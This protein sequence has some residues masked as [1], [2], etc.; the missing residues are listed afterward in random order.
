M[1]FNVLVT[2]RVRMKG[3][4]SM[5]E[6]PQVADRFGVVTLSDMLSTDWEDDTHFVCYKVIGPDGSELPSSEQFRLRKSIRGQLEEAG[7]KITCWGFVGDWDLNENV[8]DE[9]LHAAGWDGNSK[10]KPKITWT[11]DL[12]DRFIEET[13]D[14]VE[15]LRA[16][17]LG[18]AYIYL[19]NHG[20][21]MIHLY[22]EDQPATVHE[23][24]IRGMLEEYRKLGYILD[25]ACVDWT[26]LFRAPRVMRN[27]QFTGHQQ[28]FMKWTHDNWTVA[29]LAPRMTRKVDDYAD[30]S[31][32]VGDRPDPE[33]ALALLV[34]DLSTGRKT[35]TYKKLKALLHRRDCQKLH[36][37]LTGSD[38]TLA[39]GQ[40]DVELT[41][42]AGQLAAHIYELEWSSPE[43]MY[44]LLLQ[45]A[46]QLEPDEGTHDWLEKTWGLCTRMWTKE[47][48]K[49][50]AR[51]EAAEVV[52]A[53]QLDDLG[54]LLEVMR[55]RYPKNEKLHDV[56]MA[57]IVE[58]SRMGLIKVGSALFVLRPDG[59]YDPAA[60]DAAVLPGVIRD[61]G[62]EF[63]MP[64]QIMGPKGGVSV[65]DAKWLLAQHGRTASAVVGTFGTPG[66]YIQ[67]GRFFRPLFAWAN[68]PA[69]HSEFVHTWLRLLG[70][71]K[72]KDLARWIA[73]AQDMRR[74]ICSLALVG[75]KGVGKGMLARGLQ[76]LVVGA[77]VPGS[78]EDLVADFT[79]ALTRSPFL[80][81]DEGLPS[82]ARSM[83][84]VADTFRRMVAGEP[85]WVNA[86]KFQPHVEVNIPFRILFTAN[87]TEIIHGLVGNR[88]LTP[89]DR[90]ALAE[91]IK[92]VQLQ[93]RAGTWLRESGGENFTEGWVAGKGGQASNFVLARHFKWLYENREEMFGPP[94]SDRFLVSGDM[95]SSIVDDLRVLSG[96]T[97]EVAKVC[98]YLVH[99]STLAD[100]IAECISV[101]ED[102]V[103]VTSNAVIQFYNTNSTMD[104]KVRLNEKNV[105]IALENLTVKSVRGT[106]ETGR[107]TKR[108]LR[109]R[110]LDLPF[111]L[112]HAQNHGL[113]TERIEAYIEALET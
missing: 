108:Q 68:H 92:F 90:G 25:D 96:V 59:Y 81:V 55:T 66:G 30:V 49:G 88:T 73:Y 61:L 101:G 29:S 54:E 109:W 63:L 71:K 94:D 72:W 53:K 11:R 43:L 41:R 14:V 16:K 20:A 27:G 62:M 50:A 58:M 22:D 47:A 65:A 110:K 19:T 23:E 87:S 98:V 51:K 57:G 26:R 44:A 31:E 103:W 48:A 95:E 40:R 79:P 10:K 112:E 86:G 4:G 74:S 89:A 84:D 97:P 70:G 100:E 17:D 80:I 7:A 35:D 1:N 69:V 52:E 104:K 105:G 13:A 46:E 5:S 36:D 82:S 21:R 111:L 24:I 102:G 6:A 33:E 32:Y 106:R 28:W 83:K 77:P 56:E 42:L 85:L 37:I 39:E 15:G 113:P 78:G 67:D 12:L 34:E 18:P 64:T 91:R 3:I 93:E 60:V 9:M 75:V 8:T 45:A 76:E 38:V 99:T 107:G 2:D